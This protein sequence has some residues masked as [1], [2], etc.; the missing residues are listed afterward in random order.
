ML[1]HML[2]PPLSLLVLFAPR[3]VPSPVGVVV[4]VV[5]ISRFLVMALIR[6]VLVIA[7]VVIVIA[8]FSHKLLLPRLLRVI[9][10]A[11][12]AALVPLVVF[13]ALSQLNF[14]WPLVEGT[15]P[16][17]LVDGLIS[18]PVASELNVC[19][20]TRVPS[21]MVFNDMDLAHSTKLTKCFAQS[22]L[23]HF[24]RYSRN[25]HISIVKTVKLLVLVILVIFPLAT[26]LD[27]VLLKAH[28]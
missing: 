4:V 20:A 25:I 28:W 15:L 16:I 1:L 24:L 3:L 5:V 22:I 6:N 8:R 10:V 11:V 26:P 21:R 23:S 12:V 7:V 14:D 9:I 2:G 13:G 19:K 17:Q 27:R 18:I